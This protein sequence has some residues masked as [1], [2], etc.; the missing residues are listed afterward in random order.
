MLQKFYQTVVV[1]TISFTVV[2][3]GEGIKVKD[4]N[5]LSKLIKKVWSVVGSKFATLG[6]VVEERILSRL[7]AIM[8]N[9]SYH[10]TKLKLKSSFSNRLIQ[11]H[12][13]GDKHRK[14]CILGAIRLHK[15]HA[16]THTIYCSAFYFI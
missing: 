9:V 14:S 10:S 2:S 4:T 11:P 6:E 15:A 12:C 13:L 8:D 1:S 16:K 5:R 3:W 7:L